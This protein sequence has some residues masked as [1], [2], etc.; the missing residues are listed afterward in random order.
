MLK[1]NNIKT[2]LNPLSRFIAQNLYHENLKRN[3]YI[4]LV[5]NSLS[6]YDTYKFNFSFILFD[7]IFI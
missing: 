4:C 3:V 5:A 2:Y 1:F 6:F 7:V